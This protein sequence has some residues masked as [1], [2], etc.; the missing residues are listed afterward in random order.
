MIFPAG[1]E[2]D[3]GVRLCPLNLRVLSTEV[4]DKV[5]DKAIKVCIQAVGIN[6]VQILIRIL[7]IM[8]EGHISPS[9]RFYESLA[10]IIG[11]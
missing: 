8:A 11:A 3:E 9:G 10:R 6:V 7:F 1:K 4:G 2:S 5:V